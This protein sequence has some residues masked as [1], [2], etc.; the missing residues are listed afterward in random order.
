MGA[1]STVPA[2]FTALVDAWQ[3]A[4]GGAVRVLEGVPVGTVGGHEWVVVGFEDEDT[5][6]VVD[7]VSAPEGLGSER[8]SYTVRCLVS[9]QRG[10]TQLSE[11]R[12]RAYDLLGDL[13][14]ALSADI[15]LGGLVLSAHVGPH[16]LRHYQGPQGALVHVPFG[17]EVTAYVRP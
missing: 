6:D 17:V 10:K 11:A 12:V 15:T 2:V 16:T 7:A 3:D 13:Q 5:P 14:A 1:F 9:V 4:A 8:E